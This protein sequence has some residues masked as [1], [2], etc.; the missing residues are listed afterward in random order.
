MSKKKIIL[1][2]MDGTIVDF[3]SA[4]EKAAN[5]RGLRVTYGKN[6]SMYFDIV[7][8]DL[9]KSLAKSIKREK[10]FYLN[11]KPIDGA[12]KAIKE[13]LEDENLELFFCSSPLSDYQNC[14]LEK[15]LWIEKYFGFEATKNY[16]DE[17]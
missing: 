1:I 17:G 4:F 16:L 13:M 5:N 12:I 8:D 3:K 11:M 15:Y 6:N 9:E 14:V 10:G 2:D 7:G